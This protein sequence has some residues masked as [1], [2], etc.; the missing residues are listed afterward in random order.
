MG[1]PP[2]TAQ[3]A[4]F[5]VSRN[6]EAPVFNLQIAIDE[7][8]AIYSTRDYDP[9]TSEGVASIEAMFTQRTSD[10]GTYPIT[11]DS[12][13]IYANYYHSY[14]YE[15]TYDEGLTSDVEVSE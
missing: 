2:Y 14:A 11:M 15:Y 6:G 9:T 12:N 4:K 13:I 5:T 7:T 1:L 10:L 3:V 8:T